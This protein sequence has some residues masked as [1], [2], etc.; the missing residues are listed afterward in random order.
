MLLF[1][2]ENQDAGCQRQDSH[3]DCRDGDVEKQSDSCENQIDGEQEH[4][5]VL[6]NIH[7]SFLRQTLRSG[8]PK[9]TTFE[10]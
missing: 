4:S 6:G 10:N 5:E 2:N 9:I 1:A 7:E 8:T 3:Y